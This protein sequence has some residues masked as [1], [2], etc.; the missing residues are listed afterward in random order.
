MPDYARLHADLEA[1]RSRGQHRRLRPLRPTGAARAVDAEGRE[2]RVFCSND[3]LALAQHPDV[4]AAWQGGGAGSARLISGDRPAHHALEAALSELFGRPA[5]LLSSGWHANLALLGTVLRRGDTASSDAANHASI[6]D[7]LRLS[8][9]NKV[10][11]PHGSTALPEGA[12]LHCTEGLFSMDGDRPALVRAAERAR[13]Q[14]TWL[15]VDEAHTVGVCG[16]GGR[17]EAAAQ[18]VEP[19]FLVGTLGKAYGAY[20]AFVV[21]PPVLRELLLSRGRTFLFTTGLPEPVCRA[22][23]QGLALATESR[24]GLLRDRVRRLRSGLQQLGLIAL[25]DRHI[26]P[27]VLGP[28]TMT[29]SEKLLEHGFFVPG[30]RAPTVPPGQER[31]R[32]TLSAAHSDDDIDQ[33][34][35]ALDR[36]LSPAGRGASRLRA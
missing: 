26:V 25:G 28:Q 9:A 8:R 21:G 13:A 32:I 24:R 22:A 36:L 29:I 4:L 31:L 7:G 2:L 1:V 11:L 18:G 6:I 23:L 20:G 16:P 10:V 19:D 12:R 34:L 33:L 35:D 5:T 15:M 30:I 17:G 14:G 27:L 3:Y